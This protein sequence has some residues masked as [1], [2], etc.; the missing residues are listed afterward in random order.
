LA[1]LGVLALIV[2]AVGLF[3]NNWLQHRL[4]HVSEED[5]RVASDMIQ[6]A[7]RFEGW[8]PSI[9]VVQGQT[10]KKGDVLVE[11]DARAAKLKLAELIA[12]AG[13]NR[14]ERE[15]LLAQVAMTDAET[16][17]RLDAQQHRV[18]AMKAAA[19]AAK[20][21]YDFAAAEAARAKSLAESKVVSAQR[22]E[23]TNADLKDA[24]EKLTQTSAELATNQAQ[25]A[26]AQAALQEGEV[27]RRRIDQLDAELERLKAIEDQQR[28]E[29]ADRT[30]KSPIDGV[31]DKIFSNPGEYVRA[32]QRLMI[33]HDPNDI[34]VDANIRETEVRNIG[35]GA[36]VKI[37]VD[38]YPDRVFTGTVIAV[39][40]SAT[41]QYALLPNPNPSGN[42]T[43]IAQRLPIR[44]KVD[45]VEGLL[46]PGMMVE[47][48]VLVR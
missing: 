5:A 19:Q 43:K 14:A 7:S 1:R 33:I 8:V 32:G 13:S 9:P 24:A 30:I 22:V 44:V 29:I 10:V 18:E 16:K 17:H 48:D 47:I 12:Q 6:M 15:T 21:R 45:Q 46:R 42:F 4:A 25:L 37:A 36:Q 35:V 38:A 31:V 39:G 41:S 27:L 34:W 20:A 28:L 11:M 2:I 23:Q 26:E 40:S 3:A